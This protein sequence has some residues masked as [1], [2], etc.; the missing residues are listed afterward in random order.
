MLF[1]A[2][3]TLYHVLGRTHGNLRIPEQ[4]INMKVIFGQTD[5]LI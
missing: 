5:L 2:T 4:Q 3:T 1:V